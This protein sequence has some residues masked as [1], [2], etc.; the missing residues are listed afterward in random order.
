MGDSGFPLLPVPDGAKRTTRARIRKT[1]EL[2]QLAY[3]QGLGDALEQFVPDVVASIVRMN[4]LAPKVFDLVEGVVEKP[5]D[6][7]AMEKLKIAN[8]LL[9][10]VLIEQRYLLDRVHG[11]P[12]QHQTVESTSESTEVQ[13]QVQVDAS[14]TEGVLSLREV[15]RA[16]REHRSA[17]GASGDVVDVDVVG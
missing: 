4:E 3:E 15:L 11:K 2:T 7:G 17:A 16:A 8:S 12:T 5:D 1:N 6:E 13:V 14:T 10:T 9:K